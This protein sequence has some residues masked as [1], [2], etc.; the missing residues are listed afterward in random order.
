[1]FDLCANHSNRFASVRLILF[2]LLVRAPLG[3]SHMRCTLS[4]ALEPTMLITLGITV[5][6]YLPTEHYVRSLI[7]LISEC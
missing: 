4:V 6:N 7:A 5:L 3:D 2:T 1:M